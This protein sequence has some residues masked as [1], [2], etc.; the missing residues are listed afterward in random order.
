[1]N[2]YSITNEYGKYFKLN[3]FEVWHNENNKKIYQQFSSKM[4]DK[5]KGVP[6]I[7]IGEQSFIGFSSSYKEDI[8]KAITSQYKNSYDVYFS[9]KE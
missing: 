8:I 9:N 4:G 6:Y 3:K 7:I 2:D 1:M 5:S